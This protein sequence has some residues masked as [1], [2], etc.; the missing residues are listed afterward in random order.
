MPN[1]RWVSL[2]AEKHTVAP[3]VL[4]AL[5]P[6]VR[7]QLRDVAL[8]PQRGVS[9]VRAFR[10]L[11]HADPAVARDVFRQIMR[12]PSEDEVARVTSADFLSRLTENDG[13]LLGEL[14]GM[15]ATLKQPAARARVSRV[16]GRIG[17]RD[18]RES[19]RR[20]AEDAAEP[21]RSAA[22]RARDLL[23]QR[24]GDEADDEFTFEPEPA[25][26]ATR[27]SLEAASDAGARQAIDHV[28]G[29]VWGA[30]L[31]PVRAARWTCEQREMM[32]LSN[33]K[34]PAPD[35]ATG[36]VLAVIAGREPG[37]PLWEVDWIVLFQRRRSGGWNIIS[38]AADGDP[39]W[40]GHTAGL[41]RPVVLRTLDGRVPLIRATVHPT[42]K[43]LPVSA[44]DRWDAPL[45]PKRAPQPIA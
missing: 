2:L 34:G 35:R 38:R 12:N 33:A 20:L 45:R 10:W 6:D 9:R 7:D 40:A 8:H 5:P 1:P 32:A 44:I 19:L 31:T 23:R 4:R 21:V 18:A 41:D 29:F 25:A 24:L 13:E 43:S 26:A 3:E 15:T 11:L 36:G 16:L 28:R 17:G 42:G 30:E 14:A 39:V 37:E 27:L 22:S